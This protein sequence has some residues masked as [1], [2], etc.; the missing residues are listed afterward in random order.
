ML[1]RK[2]CFDYVAFKREIFFNEAPKWHTGKVG[3]GTSIGGISNLGQKVGDKFTKLSKTG[4]SMNCLQ[5]IFCNFLTKN[6]KI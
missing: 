2:D 4:F 1:L 3:P 5:L 6:A